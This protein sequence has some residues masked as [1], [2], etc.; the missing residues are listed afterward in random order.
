M[1][2][3]Y[4][5]IAITGLFILITIAVAEAAEIKRH[6]ILIAGENIMGTK[7]TI[8]GYFDALKNKS[9]WESFLGDEMIFTS[10]T[11]PV[12]KVTGKG[13]YIEATKKFYS[14]IVSMEMRDVIIDGEKACALTHYELRGPNGQ[15]GTDVAEV[16]TVKDGK[17][18]SFGIYFDSA[19]FPK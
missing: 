16:F 7:E 12:K 9:G 4:R 6:H 3:K 8:N 2:H 14:G 1:N 13:A 17:I 10:F 11:S 15:F 5:L 18:Q 19:P